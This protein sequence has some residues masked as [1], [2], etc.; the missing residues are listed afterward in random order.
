M[1]FCVM[2][3]IH[4]CW[5]TVE[6]LQAPDKGLCHL[7]WKGRM[8][9]DLPCQRIKGVFHRNFKTI[10][11]DLCLLFKKEG[12]EE[13]GMFTHRIFCRHE[14]F[15]VLHAKTRRLLAVLCGVVPP[16]SYYL[17]KILLDDLIVPKR[18]LEFD[19]WSTPCSLLWSHSFVNSIYECKFLR[20]TS[21]H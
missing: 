16:K 14:V 12:F 1:T 11:I 5:M 21:S 19:Q 3:F 9:N 8:E 10:T 13:R 7:E 6:F 18:N 15:Q 20:T 2:M 17:W 4:L